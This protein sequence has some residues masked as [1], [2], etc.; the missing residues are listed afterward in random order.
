MSTVRTPPS[1]AGGPAPGRATAPDAAEGGADAAVAAPR[2]R[3]RR[4]SGRTRALIGVA[5]V[6][7]IVVAGVVGGLTRTPAPVDRV[8]PGGPAPA[9]SLPPVTAAA[10]GGGSVTLASAAGH[11]VVINFF[12]AWCPPCRQELPLLAAASRGAPD[13]RFIGVDL[14]DSRSAAQKLLATVGVGY[15]AGFDPGDTVATRYRLAGTPTTIFIDARGTIV[16]RVE[17]PLT[18]ARLDWWLRQLRARR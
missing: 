12:G 16:G 3:P 4:L 8:A 2:R 5:T 7:F 15:P 11:P 9:F 1:P 17:G 14:E 10:G 6:G 18:R 13:V